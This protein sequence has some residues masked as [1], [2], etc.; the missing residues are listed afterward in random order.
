MK[1]I[2]VGGDGFVGRYIARDLMKRGERVLICDINKSDIPIYPQ[3]EHMFV[4]ITD[5]A[6]VRTIPI[7]PDDIVYGLAA[8]LLHP[9]VKRKERHDYFFSV[10]FDG[11]RHV[12]DVAMD[13]GCSKVIQ[14]STDM[15]YGR[16]Q[17][18]APLPEHHPRVP[19]GEYADSKKA[20]ED[21]CIAKRSEGLDVSIFRPRLIIGPGRLGILTNLFKLIQ[22][23]LPVPLIGSGN[24]RYQMISVFDCASA[25]IASADRG[26]VNSEFNLGSTTPPRVKELLKE[27]IK[28][29][30]SRSFLLP[31]PA[32][33]VKMALRF[34]DWINM[35]LLVPEQFEIADSDYVIDVSNLERRLDFVPRYTDRDMF[36]RAY[37]DFTEGRQSTTTFVAE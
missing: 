12:V 7:E 4:D 34:L 32:P 27:V 30:D 21:Y 33:L 29:A 37:S 13:K 9:I 1:H 14:F 23:G 28:L 17:M 2:L 35:P 22:R 20:I 24:N 15:V 3:A 18:P 8:V 26:V 5:L 36:L 16:M 19:I 6:Q 31:T 11:A 10:D 25:A